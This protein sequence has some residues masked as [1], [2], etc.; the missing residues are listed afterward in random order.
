MTDI[1]NVLEQRRGTHGE[2][3]D[4]AAMTQ[5]LKDHMRDGLRWPSLSSHERETLD[6][7]AH[8]IGRILSGDP[9]FPDHWL[10]I[11]GYAT[12]SHDRNVTR[13]EMEVC[14]FASDPR[15]LVPFTETEAFT[16][17][18]SMVSA[19]EEALATK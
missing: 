14:S 3:H 15:R 2:Y 10:D 7:I 16:A 18:E 17:T 13:K 11:A 9:H 1:T 5:K 6:M 8:K 4:H 19:V 12:L